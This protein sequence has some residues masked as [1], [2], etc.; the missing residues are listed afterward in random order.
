[1][2]NARDLADDAQ[3]HGRRER[4]FVPIIRGRAS[5]P[6]PLAVTWMWDTGVPLMH[7][8]QCGHGQVPYSLMYNSSCPLCCGTASG[9]A[10]WLCMALQGQRRLSGLAPWGTG[11]IIL[12][13]QTS[14]AS[15]P[16]VSCSR[17]TAGTP[18][19]AGP[20]PRLLQSISRRYGRAKGQDATRLN[21][22]DGWCSL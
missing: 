20:S 2:L 21:I 5:D 14:P 1:M 4:S 9:K 10:A 7:P 13:H 17:V 12:L 16:P 11:I 15:S 6:P 3:E 22:S 8:M 19:R 18:S